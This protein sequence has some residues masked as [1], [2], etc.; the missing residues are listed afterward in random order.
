MV[1]S[2]TYGLMRASILATL[3]G[4][5][6]IAALGMATATQLS[7]TGDEIFWPEL[8]GLAAMAA[9][10]QIGA[11]MRG[12]VLRNAYRIGSADEVGHVA[13]AW[14]AAS[15]MAVGVDLFLPVR[16]VPL[17]ALATALPF[18]LM[19]MLG[20][21]FAWRFMQDLRRRP[22]PSRAK[23]RVIVFGAGEGGD[24]IVRAMMRDPES[25][26]VAVAML[27]DDVTKTHREFHG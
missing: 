12:R 9:T 27:D 7:L 19:I 14:I 16:P 20:T 15:I 13:L 18:S 25:Q 5:A 8:M 17:L 6:W 2:K 26:Y 10:T 22:N 3:D 4:S 23:H 1:H 11:G 21:R 24:Q